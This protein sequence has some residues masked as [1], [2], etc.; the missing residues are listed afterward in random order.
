MF[1]DMSLTPAD[2]LREVDTPLVIRSSRKHVTAVPRTVHVR[3]DSRNITTVSVRISKLTDW[4]SV[5]NLLSLSLQND[6]SIIV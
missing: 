3:L 2:A 1:L 6:N 4:S 5:S